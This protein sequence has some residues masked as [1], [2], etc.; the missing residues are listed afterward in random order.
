MGDNLSKGSR[1]LA[2]LK[3]QARILHATRRRQGDMKTTWPDSAALSV[4]P[5]SSKSRV[6]SLRWLKLTNMLA[7]V[8]LALL[9]FNA[10]EAYAWGGLQSQSISGFSRYCTYSDGGVLTVG[11]TELC[12]INNSGVF[13][14]HGSPTIT[15]ENRNAGFGSLTDQRVQGFSRYCSYSD[16]AVLTVGSTELCPLTDK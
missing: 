10:P 11:S 12:P 14:N 2:L 3:T 9:A 16:G 5:V 13:Q 7:V 8:C 6:D 1:T 4:A 15:I